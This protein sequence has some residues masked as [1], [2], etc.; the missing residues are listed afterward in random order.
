MR[1]HNFFLINKYYNKPYWKWIYKDIKYI[2]RSWRLY[3]KNNRRNK[4]V[5]FYP[6]YPKRMNLLHQIFKSLDYNITNN[7]NLPF[8]YGIKCF[9]ITID[10]GN[11][12]EILEE[13]SRNHL[14]IN[15]G[16][17]DISKTMVD[18]M[19]SEVFEYSSLVDPLSY[20]GEFI[21]KSDMNA[22]HDGVI[23]AKPI[24]II[25]DGF[26]YQRLI[27]NTYDANTSVEMR[28]PVMRSH[29]PF[30]YYKYKPINDRFGCILL[31]AERVDTD[32]ALTS[33]EQEK[34]VL[35][36]KKMK[37]DFTEL[38]ILR[39]KDSLKIYI[40]DANNNPT[41]PPGFLPRKEAIQRLAKALNKHL[42]QNNN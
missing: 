6:E 22:T 42:L 9:D 38:D 10:S 2:I 29:I 37:L 14:I 13:L 23:F 25:K 1:K 34:I 32:E 26:I 19:F 27:N 36:C 30:V 5:L 24:S 11:S 4:T 7:P 16:S 41:G 33:E 39:D 18:K 20:E 28:V 35:F 40:T 31:K 12:S 21:Q 3:Y 15:K 8:Q 17:I